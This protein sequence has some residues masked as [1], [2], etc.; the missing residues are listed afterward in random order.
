MSGDKRFVPRSERRDS[1][2]PNWGMISET[3]S[4]AMRRDFWSGIGLTI[5][6][7]PFCQ[8]VLE[9]EDIAIPSVRNREF[10]DVHADDLEGVTDSYGM[11]RCG[12]Q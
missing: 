2:I 3:N 11:Q 10:H 12:L 5:D 9:Y 1:G 4:F 6:H 7:W 8:E